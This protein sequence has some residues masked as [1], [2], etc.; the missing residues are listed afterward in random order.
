MLGR[1]TRKCDEIDKTS[2]K[3][4]DAV[5]NYLDMKDFSDMNPVVNN[6][7]IDMAKL[8][9]NYNKDASDESKKYFV[10][11]I[12]ARLQR[13]K[14]RIKDL[15]EDKFEINSNIYRKNEEIKSIDSYIEYIKNINPDEIEN[16]VEFLT[17]LDSIQSLKKERVISEHRDEI[18]SVKQIYGKNEKPEDYLE[19]FEKYI[20]ENQDKLDAL[21]L[22]KENPKLFKRKDLKELKYILDGEGYKET[23]LNS[24]YGKVQNVNIT[25]DILSY[26][27]RVLKGSTI[28]DKE[29]K[30]Q[31]VEKRIKRLKNWNPVQLKIIEKIISQLRENTYLTEEDFKIGI[32][33]DNFGGYNK[34][35]QKLEE[36]LGDIVSII[37]EEIILN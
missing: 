31:D 10:E 20:R 13:K 7:Q 36:K 24:A 3:V 29:E 9:E 25:A 34:I 1:A 33:K 21:K 6:P 2:Y 15:G 23:E 22:L 8:L 17:F 27:K 32:F 28:L 16:E 14:K 30:I 12:V 4:F 19:N 11:Q 35:N 18:R 5:R 26:I 37:N